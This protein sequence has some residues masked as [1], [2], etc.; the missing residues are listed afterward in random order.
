MTD[1]NGEVWDPLATKAA[2]VDQRLQQVLTNPRHRIP[3][4]LEA[5]LTNAIFTEAA[6]ALIRWQINGQTKQPRDPDKL[7][8][9]KVACNCHKTL[10]YKYVWRQFQS[11]LQDL[12]LT[13]TLPN[14]GKRSQRS[15]IRAD[16]TQSACA[17][18]TRQSHDNG[19][20]EVGH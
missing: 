7:Q 2:V 11:N 15:N 6:L 5:D 14:R 13:F 18:V 20:Q 12:Q 3:V 9:W 19:S 17:E 10:Y 1:Q 4:Q 8:H 16:M